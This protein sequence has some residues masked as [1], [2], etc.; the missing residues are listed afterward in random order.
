[1][2][3]GGIGNAQSRATFFRHSAVLSHPAVQLRKVHYVLS[4]TVNVANIEKG[5]FCV[6]VVNVLHV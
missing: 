5:G 1:M 6:N 4:K 2:G 3:L